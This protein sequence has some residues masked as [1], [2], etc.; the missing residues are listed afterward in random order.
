MISKRRLI[1]ILTLLLAS[2]FLLTSLAS[3]YAALNALRARIDDSELPLTSDTIYSEIQRDLLQPLFISSLMASDTFLRDWVTEGEQ[4]AD[5]MVRYLN[6]I[7]QRYGTFTSFFVSDRTYR[8]YYADGILKNVSPDEPRDLWYFRVRD[9]Q[10]D[11][12]INV[13]P[14]MA[15]H[16]SMTI[17]INYR[18]KDYQGQFI[19]A[20]GVGLT[21]SA[22]KTLI[23]TYQ[24]DYQRT[25]FF[26]D[27]QGVLTLAGKDFPATITSLT[28][29]DGLNAHVDQLLNEQQNTLIY[30]RDGETFHLNTRYISEFGWYLMVEQSEEA[31]LRQIRLTLL[32]NLT[33]CFTVTLI[34][35]SLTQI[36]IN[37]YQK[38]LEEMA[39]T[40]KLTRIANRQAIDLHLLQL[41]REQ[42]RHQVPFSVILFD[43]D[44]FKQ[45]N[46]TH[47]HMAGDAVLQNVADIVSK[48]LRG[49]DVVGRW[50][51]EEF[52]VLL[53]H[54]QLDDALKRAESIRLAIQAYAIDYE[55]KTLYTTASF[56]VVEYRDQ[57]SP[58]TLLKRSDQ[59]LYIAKQNGKNRCE[60]IAQ[61]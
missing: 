37:R 42:Q 55:E 8:Y 39:L 32:I 14:D 59:A 34:V 29:I 27:P 24:R 22:V 56:G 57:D 17:F 43:L 4:H 50:G 1:V 51:G 35:V 15:N 47:G 16:D 28:D 20:T 11:Y 48:E 49:C 18:V 10:E 21:V 60:V 26:V 45:I 44:N 6:E 40:D 3:Y 12:E 52:L 36:N 31:M 61:L 38:R 9:M 53:K 23:A 54:C 33:I 7:K 19:G 13:D 2:G 25:I 5:K 41:F 46:D 58:D 30:Q